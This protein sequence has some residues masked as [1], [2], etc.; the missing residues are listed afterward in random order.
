MSDAPQHWKQLSG[1]SNW[2][3]VS[4]P[5][6]W[7]SE[8]RE[9]ALAL[10]PAGS[11]AFLA[12]NSIWLDP[13]AQEKPLPS[14]KD[15]IAQFP[16]SR[17]VQRL[18]RSDMAGL[19]DCWRGEACLEPRGSWWKNLFRRVAWRHWTMW[20]FRRSQLLIVVTLLHTDER[21]N[22]L[23]SLSRMV[24]GTLEL[25]ETPADPPEA[26]A[27]RALRLARKKFPLLDSELGAEFHLLLGGSRLNLFN[28]YRTYVRSPEKF[29]EILLPALTTV[30]QVQEWGET[31]TEPPLDAVKD[32]L[33]PM[34]YPE[35]AW[36]ERFPEFIG[37][38][39]VGG[40]AVLYVVDEH[41]AY[42]YVRA[43]L[44]T[45][46]GISQEELHDIAIDNLQGYFERKPMEMAVAGT[47]DDVPSMLMPGRPDS[48]NASRLLSS[49]FLA[50][51]RDFVG[52]DLAIGVPGRDFF[53]AVSMKADVMLE[54]VRERVKEDFHQTDHPLTDRMLLITADGVSE[55]V[56][57]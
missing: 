14:L 47:E 51:L 31:Q 8:E 5:P 13:I 6:Q 56:D 26:F 40:L 12:F 3:Q 16:R 17:R 36:Q 33:M 46:W 35:S 42:W 41:N 45:K 9:G 52:G 19:L 7:S 15:I 39:W 34:L 20:A 22:E 38:P 23:E 53:V 4:F 37:S 32:R 55:L 29:E 57:D 49:S 50:K 1:P 10:R 24:L 43:D 2:F 11:E 18:E 48:Y 30:V 27:Q 54:H 25:P 28:F 21:D 44:T